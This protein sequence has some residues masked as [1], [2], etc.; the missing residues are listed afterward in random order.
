MPDRNNVRR[1]DDPF[2]T[3]PAADD[4]DSSEPELPTPRYN[5]G[6]LAD[7]AMIEQA[8]VVAQHI[9]RMTCVLEAVMLVKTWLR[10]RHMGHSAVDSLGSHALTILAVHLAR[11]RRLSATMSSV[12]AFR[13][14]LDF[15]GESAQTASA[16]G[17]GASSIWPLIHGA[18]TSGGL[19]EQ[20]VALLDHEPGRPDARLTEAGR[21]VG[22]VPRCV[23]A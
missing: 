6:I 19:T 2:S 7:M 15:L 8:R 22:P 3:S 12:Q 4:A 18:A 14:M 21:Q 10:Q 17:A 13:V 5:N 16:I 23:S 9:G 20:G 1:A 11:H